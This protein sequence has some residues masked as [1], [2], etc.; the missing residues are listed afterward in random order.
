MVSYRIEDPR[1]KRVVM[2]WSE[3]GFLR[4]S[5]REKID[6]LIRVFH[7]AREDH[8]KEQLAYWSYVSLWQIEFW[9]HDMG[10]EVI[11]PGM[12]SPASLAL[13]AG[14]EV[15]AVYSAS[16][17]TKTIWALG[18]GEVIGPQEPPEEALK[19]RGEERVP[20][21]AIGLKAS[22]LVAW[23]T[24]CWF[25]EKAKGDAWLKRKIQAGWVMHA[26]DLREVRHAEFG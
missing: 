3:R 14:S 6:E 13:P 11:A 2:T 9:E 8:T 17:Q 24:E 25:C 12:S 26:L 22:Q 21:P 1:W 7:R 20:V 4:D 18:P 16:Q 5:Y 15:F 23:A 19:R 10:H